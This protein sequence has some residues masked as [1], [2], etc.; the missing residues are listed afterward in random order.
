MCHTNGNILQGNLVAC[1]PRVWRTHALNRSPFFLPEV[2]PSAQDP[3]ATSC[4]KTFLQ[5]RTQPQMSSCLIFLEIFEVQGSIQTFD[6]LMIS[7]SPPDATAFQRNGNPN[8]G[9]QSGFIGTSQPC[10][11]H[12]C[13]WCTWAVVHFLR[14]D[15]GR[16][17]YS[18]LHSFSFVQQIM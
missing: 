1:C 11:V 7:C 9:W 14:Y 2:E 16:C 5:N 17:A 13:T 10:I 6:F 4:T 3:S 12:I 15:L 8:S 18:T